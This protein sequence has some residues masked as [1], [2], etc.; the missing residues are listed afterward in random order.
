MKDLFRFF[1]F[2]FVLISFGQGCL[3]A[4]GGSEAYDKAPFPVQLS[5]YSELES[6]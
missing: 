3:L 6:Q 5:Y 1:C 2:T 4:G